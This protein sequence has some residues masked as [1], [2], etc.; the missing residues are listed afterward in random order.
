MLKMRTFLTAPKD[1]AF[2]VQSQFYDRSKQSWVVAGEIE[3]RKE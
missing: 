1:G 3:F 2:L